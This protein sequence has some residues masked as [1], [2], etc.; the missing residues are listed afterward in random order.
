[1]NIAFAGLHGTGKSTIA[2][3]V[4]Q[5]FQ[6][7]FYSTGMAFRDLAQEKNMNLEEFSLFVEHNPAIDKEIDGKILQLAETSQN[8]VFEGQMP[9]YMLG[10]NLNFAILLT[11]SDDIRIQRMAARDE[12]T[13]ADQKH[14]TLMREESERQRFIDLYQVD[15]RDPDLILSTFNLIIDTTFLSIDTVRN[16]CFSALSDFLSNETR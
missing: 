6:F 7:L 1:M 15:V 10:K 2:K 4:A 12:Q 8:Y 9:V 11:C 16:I 5:E 13:F 14:E 3:E